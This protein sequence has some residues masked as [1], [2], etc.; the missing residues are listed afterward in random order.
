MAAASGDFEPEEDTSPDHEPSDYASEQFEASFI[1][2]TFIKNGADP[3]LTLKI[4]DGRDVPTYADDM[5]L[6]YA[7]ELI[8]Y[9]EETLELDVVVN[10]ET[11]MELTSYP[12]GPPKQRRWGPYDD[13]PLPKSHL[14]VRDW[15]DRSRLPDKDVLLK[16]ID[17]K[18]VLEGL[19]DVWVS[20]RS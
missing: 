10:L 5:W 14:S 18:L 15:I 1:L 8:P 9:G 19:E 4:D 2:R 12:Y 6:S 7:V 16:L 11:R 17:E 3:R 20:E 13:V